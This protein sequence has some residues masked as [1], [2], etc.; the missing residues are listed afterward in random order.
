MREGRL[1]EDQQ[2]LLR[3]NIHGLNID[4]KQSD[5]QQKRYS[6]Q[7][8]EKIEESSSFGLAFTRRYSHFEFLPSVGRLNRRDCSR[9]DRCLD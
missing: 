6:V 1:T 9:S 8:G 4:I 5:S 7:Q 2:Y 3:L